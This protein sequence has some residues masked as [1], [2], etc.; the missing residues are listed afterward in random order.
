VHPILVQFTD[1]F[2]IGTYG[3]L[4]ALGLLAAV[5]VC[6]LRGKARAIPAEVFMDLAFIA[7]FSGFLGARILYILLD[8][9]GFF[10]APGAYIFSRTGFVFIGGLLAATAACS[11]YVYL[12][13]LDFWM[14]ADIAVIGVAIGHAFGRIGCHLAGCC[15]GGVCP[16][17]GLGIRVPVVIMPDGQSVWPNAYEEH[18]RAG[19][20]EQGALQSLPIWPV[21]LYEAA[22]L[23]LLAMVLWVVGARQHRKGLVFGLYLTG[24]AAIRFA[25]EYLRGDEGRG[26]FFGGL[27]ST[28]QLLSIGLFIA[29]AVILATL[30][31]RA[32]WLPDERK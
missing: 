16:V 14:T 8:L 22:A 12:K 15:F 13:K 2:F 18:W 31:K 7:G 30:S 26:L 10:A 5:W 27:L 4:I 20:L 11:Y 1:S 28:S 23:A 6:G 29:G 21:Q 25:L 19:L 17:P 3:V 32:I 24:Y 9:P